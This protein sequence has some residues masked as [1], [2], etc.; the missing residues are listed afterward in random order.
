MTNRNVEE[1]VVPVDEQECLKLLE[2]LAGLNRP[3][4]DNDLVRD[5]DDRGATLDLLHELH[6]RM[7]IMIE[8]PLQGG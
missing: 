2:V 8:K 3:V 6:R 4:D 7:W 1:Q 5:P